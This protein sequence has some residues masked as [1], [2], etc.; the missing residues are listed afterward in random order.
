MIVPF[1]F[2]YLTPLLFGMLKLQRGLQRSTSA[3]P[4]KQAGAEATEQ[5]R[6]GSRNH[7]G[8]AENR[9]GETAQAGDAPVIILSRTP[10][11]LLG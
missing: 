3:H 5:E 2:M 1:A 4:G 11:E 9:E 7:S 6:T 8:L 10:R